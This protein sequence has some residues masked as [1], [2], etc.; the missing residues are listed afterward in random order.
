[1]KH[2]LV[3]GGGLFGHKF[4]VSTFAAGNQLTFWKERNV[5]KQ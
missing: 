2:G 3:F 1:M 4:I 5:Y